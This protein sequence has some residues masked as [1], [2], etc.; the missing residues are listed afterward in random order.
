MNGFRSRV[1]SFFLGHRRTADNPAAPVIM[2]EF[3]PVTESARAQAARNMRDDPSKRA[4][5]E[6]LLAKQLGSVALGVA[7]SRRRY[8]EAYLE[9]EDEVPE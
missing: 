5:V 3:G 4:D 9:N 1:R 7:E 8:P 6:A 2:T